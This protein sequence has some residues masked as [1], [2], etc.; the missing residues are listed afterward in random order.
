MNDSPGCF[1]LP[2]RRIGSLHILWLVNVSRQGNARGR[3][4]YQSCNDIICTGY[5]SQGDLEWRRVGCCHGQSQEKA[6]MYNTDQVTSER[7]CIHFFFFFKEGESEKCKKKK[8]R[9]VVAISW[10]HSYIS[11]L[12]VATSIKSPSQKWL[13]LNCLIIGLQGCYETD[14]DSEGAYNKC[15]HVK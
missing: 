3:D 2:V 7:C 5:D 6:W 4:V 11:E 12:F 1:E 8:V 13:A 9:K 15:W 14:Y 10:F